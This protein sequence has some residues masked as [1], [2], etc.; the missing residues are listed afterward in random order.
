MNHMDGEKE[1]CQVL[2]PVKMVT[3]VCVHLFW[4]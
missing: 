2:E 4:I 1:Q 3:G